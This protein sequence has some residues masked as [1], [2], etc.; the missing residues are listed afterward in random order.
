MI[1]HEIL[2]MLQGVIAAQIVTAS[3]DNVPNCTIVSQIYPVDDRHVAVSN[4]FFSKTFRNL[5]ENPY[6]Y[7]Q[8]LDPADTRACHL[9]VVYRRSEHEG[10]LFEEMEMQLAAIASMSGMSQVFK[11]KSAYTFEVLSVRFLPELQQPASTT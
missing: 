7:I 4:Q 11:L 3:A 2:P 10:P 9:E 5:A 6:A 8:V 1:T